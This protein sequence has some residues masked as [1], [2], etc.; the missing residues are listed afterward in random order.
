MSRLKHDG[1]ALEDIW[2][3]RV[4]HAERAYQSAKTTL[5]TAIRKLQRNEDCGDF[6]QAQF[7]HERAI[8]EYMRV[9][10]GVP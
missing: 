6:L 2:R 10:K 1:K 8:A 4:R 7:E 5:D 3:E 9:L